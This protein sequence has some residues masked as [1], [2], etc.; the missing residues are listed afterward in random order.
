MKMDS[1]QFLIA[2]DSDGVFVT[3]SRVWVTR[4]RLAEKSQWMN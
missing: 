2:Y 4:L 1:L 3:K